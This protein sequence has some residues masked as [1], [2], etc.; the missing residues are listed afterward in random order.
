MN[1]MPRKVC[2]ARAQ[3]KDDAAQLRF[4][5]RWI[6]CHV[7]AAAQLGKPLVLGEFGKKG[8]GAARAEFF[9]KVSCQLRVLYKVKGSSGLHRV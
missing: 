1:S 2:C 7:D 3:G 6:N 5:R 4:A 8:A 9:Q